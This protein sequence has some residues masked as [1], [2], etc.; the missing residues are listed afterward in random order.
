MF[1][2]RTVQVAPDGTTRFPETFFD[3]VPVQFVLLPPPPPADVR[4]C[5]N[6]AND[7][8]APTATA[9]AA[10]ARIAISTRAFL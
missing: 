7:G 8:L 10:A 9:T 6:L 2:A 3:C 4:L 1:T 5:A